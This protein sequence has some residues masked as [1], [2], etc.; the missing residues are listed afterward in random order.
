LRI[1][2]I[3]KT[4][5]SW[6][7]VVSGAFLGFFELA[8]FGME[9]APF[10]DRS[11]GWFLR[12]FSIAGIGLLAVCFLA[13]SIVATRNRRFAGLIFLTFMPVAA[14][15]LAD[16]DAGFLVWHADGGGWFETPVPS[17]GI[18]LTFLFFAPLLVVVLARRH[19]KRAAYLFAIAAS[20]AGLVFAMSRWTSVL[21]PRLAGW[22]APFL[23]FG[24]FWMGTHQLGWPS[25]FE[26]RTRS[27]LMDFCRGVSGPFAWFCE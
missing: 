16:P 25:L 19:R 12:W 8:I 18:G 27:R 14:F 22:S 4:L 13:G 1:P 5:L 2:P 10:G 6:L 24:L 11:S 3:G 15:C 17:T 7:A 20:L 9:W 21:V 23:L 26:A